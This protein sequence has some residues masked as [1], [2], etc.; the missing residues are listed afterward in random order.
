MPPPD[1]RARRA[2]LGLQRGWTCRRGDAPSL[3]LREW[4]R[5]A[6]G[7]MRVMTGAVVRTPGRNACEAGC[8]L[9]GSAGL[10]VGKH[11]MQQHEGGCYAR[12]RAARGVQLMHFDWQFLCQTRGVSLSRATK[13][14]AR[15]AGGS[16][17]GSFPIALGS[18]GC[19]SYK[20]CFCA[21]GGVSLLRER[22][23]AFRSPLDSSGAHP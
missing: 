15:V 22:P 11:G 18:F 12:W 14:G 2:I 3:R 23:R 19:T 5:G 9:A 4:R 21:T 8:A 7:L 1:S 17:D 13:P 16:P 20:E 6:W 10:F